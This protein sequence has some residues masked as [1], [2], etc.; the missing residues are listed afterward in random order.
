[1]MQTKAG[2]TLAEVLIALAIIGVIAAFAIPKV[3]SS[4]GTTHAYATDREIFN[5]L[6]TLLDQ[7][8]VTGDLEPDGSNFGTYF[9]GKI[10]AVKKCR[11]DSEAQRCWVATQRY[12]ETTQP[13]MILSNGAYLVGFRNTTVG[14]KTVMIDWNGSTG[15]NTIGDDQ[16][17]LSLCYDGN[18]CTGVATQ[19]AG[20]IAPVTLGTAFPGGLYLQSNTDLF[21]NISQ[22]Q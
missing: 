8:M 1:M 19:D 22:L 17:L 10:K 9:M 7:G 21:N 3:I 15:N 2:Y 4:S 20:T 18:G 6:Y 12:T 14:Q 16:I 13:G 5:V 11:T